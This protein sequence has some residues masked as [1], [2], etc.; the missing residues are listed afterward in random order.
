MAITSLIPVAE[1]LSPKDYIEIKKR[2]NPVLSPA[3]LESPAPTK[4]PAPL[5]SP[6][7]LESSAVTIKNVQRMVAQEFGIS[8]FELL[9]RQRKL[10]FIIPRHVAI[11]ISRQLTDLSLPRIGKRFGG[12]DHTTILNAVRR[13]SH[14][15]K[16]DFEIDAMINKII[17]NFNVD[18]PSSG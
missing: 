16:V 3:P 11:Y 12:F 15:R 10:E 14:L 17:A 2:L 8:V 13:I 18:S 9:S 5:E 6:T 1:R 4:S 7:P